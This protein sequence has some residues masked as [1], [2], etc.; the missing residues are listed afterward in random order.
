MTG[1]PRVLAGIQQAYLATDDDLMLSYLG[2]AWSRETKTLNSLRPVDPVIRAWT[3]PA[4]EPSLEQ[5]VEDLTNR[6]NDEETVNRRQWDSIAELLIRTSNIVQSVKALE[7][8]HARLIQDITTGFTKVDRRIRAITNP[9][10]ICGT[11]DGASCP[12]HSHLEPTA[13]DD[14]VCAREGCGHS[15]SSHWQE[16]TG[17]TACIFHSSRFPNGSAAC[18]CT[19]FVPAPQPAP[20]LDPVRVEAATKALFHTYN[21]SYGWDDHREWHFKWRQQAEATIRAYLKDGGA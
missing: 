16:S 20:D 15:R 14:P 11:E 17:S 19:A 8:K 12:V 1:D 9:D 7:A 5:R 4:A 21:P 13:P 3:P 10:C 6:I 18:G 2:Y